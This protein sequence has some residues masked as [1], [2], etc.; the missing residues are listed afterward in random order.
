MTCRRVRRLIPLAAGDDLGP[1]RA[2]AVRAHLAACPACRGELETFRADLA[3]LKASARA[4]GVAGW[5]EAEW[6]ALMAR[7]GTEAKGTAPSPARVAGPD[8]APRWAAAAA[9]GVVLAFVVMGVLF[10]EPSPRPDTAAS[11][12][13]GAAVATGEQDRLTMTMVSPE[14]G[15]QI[16]WILDKNFDWQGD[17]Q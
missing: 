4:E 10:R 3:E 9:M 1:R 16:V 15:L 6:S 12:S 5:T 7:V 17:R 14:T 8:F 11:D 2:T 13:T